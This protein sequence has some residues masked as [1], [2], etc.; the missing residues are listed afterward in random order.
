L[1]PRGANAARSKQLAEK[2]KRMLP[3]VADVARAGDR[4]IIVDTAVERFGRL[5][6]LVNNPGRGMKHVSDSFMTE[7]GPL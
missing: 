4:E 3:L 1:R 6:I 2:Q 5:D 7:P